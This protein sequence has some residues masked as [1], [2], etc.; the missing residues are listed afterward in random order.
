MAKDL[1]HEAVRQAL[2]TDGWSVTHD[3]Y[4]L[5]TDL[6]KDALTVDLGAEKLITA[7]RGIEKIAVEVKSFLGDSLIYDFHSAVG[8]MLV[9][10]VNLDLQEPDRVLYLAIPEPT[11]ERMSRQRVF[12]VVAERYKLN[13]VVYEPLNK[14]IV[15]WIAHNK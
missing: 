15:K 4:R 6:L 8:Q 3:G 10:Q 14:Q 11:Y 5:M 1:F 9:Y 2:L 12:E 13:F 7:E